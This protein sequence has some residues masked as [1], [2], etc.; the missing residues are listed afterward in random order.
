MAYPPIEQMIP[1]GALTGVDLPEVVPVPV[2]IYRNIIRMNFD[3]KHGNCSSPP[4]L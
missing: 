4:D 2:V 3:T 1:F